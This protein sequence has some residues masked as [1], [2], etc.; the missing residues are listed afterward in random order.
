M[1]T[2][3]IILERD[4][5]DILEMYKTHTLQEVGDRYGV[6]RERIRQ[7]I[8]KQGRPTRIKRLIEKTCVQCGRSVKIFK[9]KWIK[10]P[11]KCIPCQWKLNTKHSQE[12]NPEWWKEY[13]RQYEIKNN[14]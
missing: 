1:N 11:Y 12:Q 10:E 8:K 2:Q 5:F 4:L 3:K 7:I 13:H 14:L 9:T 6:T